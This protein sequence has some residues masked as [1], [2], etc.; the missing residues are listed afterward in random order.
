MSQRARF[1]IAIAVA[2]LCA[3]SYAMAFFLIGN[4]FGEKSKIVIHGNALALLYVMCV[5]GMFSTIYMCARAVFDPEE[6][7]TF[8]EPSYV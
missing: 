7:P 4:P 3:S 6:V 1:W 8:P 5:I 2:S